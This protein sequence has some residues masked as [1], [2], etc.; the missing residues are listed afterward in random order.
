MGLSLIVALRGRLF[1]INLHS[2]D[3]VF[4]HD[5]LFQTIRLEAGRQPFRRFSLFT[6][7]R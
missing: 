5:V 6:L 7:S 3:W 2:T 1:L 4:C